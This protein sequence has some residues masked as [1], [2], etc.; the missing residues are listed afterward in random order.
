MQMNTM[1][2]VADLIDAVKSAADSGTLSKLTLGAYRGP[3]PSL[4]KLLVRLVEIQGKRKL[5]LVYRHKTQDITKNFPLAA[6]LSEIEKVTGA[7]FHAAHLFSTTVEVQ[8]QREPGGREF[9]TRREIAAT[10]P[11]SLEHDRTK[12]RV[13]EKS[14]MPWLHPLGLTT[15][16]GSV[17]TGK[18]AKVRQ[19]EKFTELLAH[20]VKPEPG[21]TLHVADMGCGSGALTFA[22]Y[23][24]LHEHIGAEVSVTGVEARPELVSRANA[25]AAEAGYDGLKFVEG[26]ISDFPDGQI[27]ALVALHACNTATDDAAFHGIS[28]QAHWL[29]L[30]P[31]CHKELRPQLESA[32]REDA[33]LRHGIFL[34]RHAEMLTDSLRGLLLESQGYRVK[35]FEFIS[36]EHAGRNTML[37][38]EKDIN[39]NPD[40]ALQQAIELARASGV[41]SQ[42]LANLL[43]VRFIQ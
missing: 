1:T 11:V 35:V 15:S 22:V 26:Q 10:L 9:I 25:A 38:A 27:N 31:C 37:L 8:W 12:E 29:I 41:H 7:E 13:L 32:A 21:T 36:P 5:S 40:K 42:H 19:I 20:H 43:G 39:V 18:T 34:E 2:P 30:A 16:D 14:A 17:K 28:N 3:D 6:G 23:Q 4:K 24:F 33:I